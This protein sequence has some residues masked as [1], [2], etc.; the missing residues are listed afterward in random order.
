MW[1]LPLATH[2]SHIRAGDIQAKSDTTAA[3]NPRR[4]FF[5]MVLYTK[6]PSRDVADQPNATIFFGDGTSTGIDK[7]QRVGNGTVIPS[8]P[9]TKVNVYYFEHIYN[10]PGQYLVSFVGEYRNKEVRNLSNPASQAFYLGTSITID[11]ALGINRSPVLTAPAIDQ[12]TA[13]QVFLHSPGAYDADGDSL[14]FKLRPSKRAST[15]ATIITRGGVVDTSTVPGFQYPNKYDTNGQRVAYLGTPAGGQADFQQDVNTGLIVWNAPSSQSIGEYNFAFVVEEWRRVAGARPR[16]IG[17]VIR[18]MQIVVGPSTN[19]RPE[20]TIPE[21]ICVVA[22]TTV[23]GAITATDPDR[24]PVQL[25]AYGTFPPIT[26]QQT[27]T[28]PPTARGTFRWVTSCE[29]VRRDPYLFTFKAQDV[30]TGGN[31]PLID[32]KIWR[33]RVIGPPPQTLQAQRQGNSTRVVLTW[34]RY[35]CTQASQMLIFRKEN[36]SDFIPSDCQTGIPATA[37]YTQIGA[38]DAGLSSFLDDNNGQGLERGKTYCYR[39]YAVFPLPKGGESIASAEACVTLDGTSALLTNV[40]VDRT[41]AN[42]QVTVKWTPPLNQAGFTEPAGYRLYRAPGQNVAATS[43]AFKRVFTTNSLMETTFVDAG[44]NTIDSAF[45]YKL[46]FFS[47]DNTSPNAAETRETTAPAS[48]VRLSGRADEAASGNV[49]TWTYNVPWDNTRQPTTIYRRAPGSPTFT[50]LATVAGTAT[51]GTYTDRGSAANP[52]VAGETYCY[53]V[54]TNG[55]YTSPN[56]PNLLNSSQEI[57]VAPVPCRPILTLQTTNCD[58]LAANLYALPTTVI[59]PNQRYTNYLRWQ[60]DANS[61]PNCNLAVTG[62]QV[63]YRSPDA[64]EYQLLA[65]TVEPN[66]V[67]MGLTTV[68]GCYQVRAVGSNGELSAFSNEACNDECQ[69]FLLPNIFTPNNDGVNDTFR[70][71]VTSSLRRTH[72][73]AFNRWGV[74][75]YEGDQ[76]PFINWDGGGSSEERSSGPQLSD[77]MY[78]YLAEVEFN[79][80]NRTKRTYKGWVQINR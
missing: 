80:L 33:V 76:D 78:F 2:A 68:S 20:V 13:N 29:D 71:K 38:I 19:L 77:G 39:I 53:Y 10:A 59:G 28:G 57:C 31:P 5:K 52:L 61:P 65:T 3:R 41:A 62:Y 44:R 25:F 8:A 46:E 49:L 79:D 1:L 14:A 60:L 74:K 56:L 42:G 50:L 27:A 4:V 30:P 34:D 32:E 67:H 43:T 51:S 11:P 15:P 72:F 21:D 73:T 55:A 75:V 22:G 69:L 40:T 7:V 70:P 35:Q 66:Y 58:S 26:F 54:Q 47:R 63:Y 37:G 23:N 24:N 9:N 45:T 16:L 12:A 48:S 17:T 64:T 18:D 36:P 6:L